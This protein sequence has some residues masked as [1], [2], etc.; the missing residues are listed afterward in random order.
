MAELGAVSAIIALVGAG[1]KVSIALFDLA[2]AVG[3]AGK[4]LQYIATEV[5]LFCSVLKEL[6]STLEDADS[7]SLTPAA[8]SLARRIADEC[9]AVISEIEGTVNS[10]RKAQG[11]S[12]FPSVDWID[13]VKWTFKRSKIQ[14]QR[15]TLES[16]KSTLHLFL[17]TTKW[18][19][20]Q[21]ERKYVAPLVNK[22]N[23]K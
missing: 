18:G 13:K 3:A 12:D 17:A 9:Q 15:Q 2:S 1:T 4:E 11:P 23:T 14:V 22:Y 6:Q 16:C 20:R 8:I 19:R 7:Y 5:S 10:L 21:S